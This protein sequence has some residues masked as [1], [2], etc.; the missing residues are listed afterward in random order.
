MPMT[1]LIVPDCLD[2]PTFSSALFSYSA[3][4]K[5]FTAETSTL[6][7]GRRK[8]QFGDVDGQRGFYLMSE[9]TGTKVAYVVDYIDTSGDDIA[10]WNC[11]P[12][13]VVPSDAVGTR[14]LIIND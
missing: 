12:Y 14:V 2:V 10:G 7:E 4:R 9:K 11:R 3:S 1:R 5:L 8:P 6:C 13:G